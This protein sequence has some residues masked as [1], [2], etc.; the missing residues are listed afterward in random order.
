MVPISETTI[1]V[2]GASGFIGQALGPVLGTNNHL[3]GF[4]AEIGIQ[5]ATIN[6][7]LATARTQKNASGRGL[8]ATGSVVGFY[9]C[10][11]QTP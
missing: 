3:V 1:A 11:R 5:R 9:S 6:T 10:H 7:D 8:A 2:A 4:T